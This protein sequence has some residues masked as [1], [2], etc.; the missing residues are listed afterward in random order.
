[1]LFLILTL[2]NVNIRGV[3]QC[4]YMYSDLNLKGVWPKPEVNKQHNAP[5]MSYYRFTL[6]CSINSY[7]AFRLTYYVRGMLPAHS[8]MIPSS[9]LSSD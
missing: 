9:T 8:T 7:S 2:V 6:N 3:T 5:P 1:M 4:C